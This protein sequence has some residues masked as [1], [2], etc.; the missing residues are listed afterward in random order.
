MGKFSGPDEMSN[1]F[2]KTMN[3]GT[4]VDCRSSSECASHLELGLGTVIQLFSTLTSL[5][6]ITCFDIWLKNKMHMYN[7][8]I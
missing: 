3:T 4:M 7:L 8:L 6:F 5:V 1:T 2:R